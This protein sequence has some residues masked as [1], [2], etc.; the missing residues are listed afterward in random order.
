MIEKRQDKIRASQE[1]VGIDKVSVA[2]EF[3][4]YLQRP[5]L[6]RDR[7]PP[8][9]V[10]LKPVRALSS[11]CEVGGKTDNKNERCQNKAIDE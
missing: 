1:V 8:L 10:I 11:G 6:W 7:Q 2:A 9:P 5:P 3:P 4:G